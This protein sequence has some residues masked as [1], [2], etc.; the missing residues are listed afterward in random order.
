MSNIIGAKI[1]SIFEI[2]KFY[3]VFFFIFRKDAYYLTTLQSYNLTKHASIL[4]N[5]YLLIIYIIIYYNIYYQ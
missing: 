2:C 1:Q 5:G 3:A 4:G